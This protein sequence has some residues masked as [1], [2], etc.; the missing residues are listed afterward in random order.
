[1]EFVSKL[2]NAFLNDHFSFLIIIKILIKYLIVHDFLV[3]K[4]GT[5]ST[6]SGTAR[7]LG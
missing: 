1:M 5:V 3:V 6:A 7:R 2:F 4:S